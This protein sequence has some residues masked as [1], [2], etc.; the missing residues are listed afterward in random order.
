MDISRLSIVFQENEKIVLDTG[1]WIAYLMKE[2]E[3]LNHLLD[4]YYF[5][6]LTPNIL[7]GNELLLSE[8]FY[9]VCRRNGTQTGLLILEELKK[10]LILSD[11]YSLVEIAGHIKCQFA[12]SLVDCYS[13]ATSILNNCPVVFKIEEELSHDIVSEIKQKFDSTIILI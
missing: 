13:I 3:Q 1:I 9:I 7:C 6:D 11:N 8:I 5:S 2:N 12:I 10:I 4:N